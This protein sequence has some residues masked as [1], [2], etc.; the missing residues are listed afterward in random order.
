MHGA[1]EV[2]VNSVGELLTGASSSAVQARVGAGAAQDV[3]GKRVGRCVE[4]Q[5]RLKVRRERPRS[6][7]ACE[8]LPIVEQN[9]IAALE[10][11][12]EHLVGRRS[13]RS[14]G[15]LRKL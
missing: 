13:T 4:W 15:R 8:R 1:G 2:V 10:A 5:K 11:R 9:V 7:A 6:V 12:D 14:K 3:P